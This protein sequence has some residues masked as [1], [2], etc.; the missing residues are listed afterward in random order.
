MTQNS[1][2]VQTPI[3][4]ADK[5][6]IFCKIIAKQIPADVI[7][8]DDGFIAFHDIRPAMPVHVLLIPKLHIA[9]LSDVCT[10]VEHANF[11]QNLL[12]RMFYLAAELAQKLGLIGYQLKLHNGA[13]G[14][15]E[16]FHLHLHIMGRV[17]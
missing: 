12:G 14:G 3:L 11:Y 13:A 9:M 17:A 8:E 7:Y 4:E 5:N 16:V 10:H 15:Q 2:K 6:C 1:I